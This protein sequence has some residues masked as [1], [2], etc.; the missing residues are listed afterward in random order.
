[1]GADDEIS[2]EGLCIR[3]VVHLG[4]KPFIGGIRSIRAP[5]ERYQCPRDG[6]VVVD[7]VPL[8]CRQRAR[9]VVDLLDCRDDGF[10]HIVRIS[11][12][13]LIPWR[14]AT[15]DDQKAVERPIGDSAARH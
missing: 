7:L 2:Y 10:R 9:A 1:W 8:R 11:L 4:A 15:F 13:L 3:I 5:W 12:W 14:L 6:R